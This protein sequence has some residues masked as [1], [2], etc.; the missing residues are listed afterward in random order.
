MK[1]KR[2][3]LYSLAIHIVVLLIF[4]FITI[5]PTSKKPEEEWVEIQT[6]PTTI[7][8]KKVS[9]PTVKKTKAGEKPLKTKEEKTPEEKLVEERLRQEMLARKEIEEREKKLAQQLFGSSS[10]NVKIEGVISQR[11]LI[12][13]VLPPKLPLLSDV[14][15]KVKVV[16]D[17]DGYV[18]SVD[19]LKK[20]D[21][22]AERSVRNVLFQWRFEPLKKNIK[23]HLE[24]GIITFRFVVNPR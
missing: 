23:P 5:S 20:G 6:L 19:F 9:A 16:V 4:A 21:P 2:P 18:K 13:Y 3:Y 12:N 8:R 1:D 7:I 11:R 15:I 10:V 22:T 24:E 14:T 17:P